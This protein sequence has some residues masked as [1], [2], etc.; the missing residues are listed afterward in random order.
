[1]LAF[2]VE[3]ARAQ[4]EAVHRTLR[5]GLTHPANDVYA[6]RWAGS[7]YTNGW[8]PL[9]P[10]DTSSFTVGV[11]QS[12][13][14]DMYGGS[15]G[16]A[17]APDDEYDFQNELNTHMPPLS[18]TDIED[19]C[20]ILTDNFEVAVEYTDEFRALPWDKDTVRIYDSDKMNYQGAA[21]DDDNDDDEDDFDDEGRGGGSG[22][23][24]ASGGASVRDSGGLSAGG[25][26]DTIEDGS[27]EDDGYNSAEG[28]MS[29]DEDY[30]QPGAGR[31]R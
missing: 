13:I 25:A 30:T 23:G 7:E 1:M 24:E 2:K 31:R 6:K 9:K 15:D 21:F 4:N 28:Q 8:Y 16:G 22:D 12:G 11:D 3:A 18:R 26:L 19:M 27:E 29:E 14:E 20:R 5:K 10:A 17:D